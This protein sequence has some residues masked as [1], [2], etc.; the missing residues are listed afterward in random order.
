MT[1]MTQESVKRPLD[2]FNG[3]D[4]DT[5]LALLWLNYLDIKSSLTPSPDYKTETIASALFD[6]FT[7]SSYD[8]QLQAMRDIAGKQNTALS[9]EYAAL[10]PSAKLDIWLMLA[11]GMENGTIVGYPSDYNLPES[12]QEFISAFKQLDFEQQ[13][14][15]IR[16][17]VAN[18]GYNA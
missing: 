12:T 18:M 4:V 15:F 7:G 10:S 2:L 9:R 16:N 17:A 11:Q 3:Y 1:Y 5:Q 14:N 8:E 6:R 13:I